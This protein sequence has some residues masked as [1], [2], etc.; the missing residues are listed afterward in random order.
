MSPPGGNLVDCWPP[1]SSLKSMSDACIESLMFR[2][3]ICEERKL[4]ENVI[5]FEYFFAKL[6]FIIIFCLLEKN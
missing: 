4:I 5:L 6:F 1:A 3:R 2:K